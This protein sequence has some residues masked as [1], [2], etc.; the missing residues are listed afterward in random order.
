MRSRYAKQMTLMPM[1]DDDLRKCARTC[2][3]NKSNTIISS[4]FPNSAKMRP[5]RKGNKYSRPLCARG[6]GWRTVGAIRLLP[7]LHLVVPRY[8]ITGDI[9]SSI[10]CAFCGFILLSPQKTIICTQLKWPPPPQTSNKRPSQCINRGCSVYKYGRARVFVIPLF[11][12]VRLSLNC[13]FNSH[14]Y[15]CIIVV[16]EG[17][18]KGSILA[19]FGV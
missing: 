15:I 5:A 2:V 8:R 9:S 14:L 1:D 17:G 12:Y 10:G 19:D 3:R 7:G 16:G 18:E 4:Q 6:G 13:T 11:H